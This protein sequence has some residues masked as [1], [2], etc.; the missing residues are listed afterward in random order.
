MHEADEIREIL[1]SADEKIT[2][3]INSLLGVRRYLK[4]ANEIKGIIKQGKILDWGSGWGQMSYLLKNRGFDVVSYEVEA[5]ESPLV[6]KTNQPMIIGND[7]VKLPFPDVYF[8]AVLSSGVLEHVQDDK[9]SIG[10]IARILKTKGYF[11]IFMLPNRYSYIEYLSDRLGR[12]AHPIKYSVGEIHRL[13]KE[14]GF[15]PLEFG[16][17]NFLP[18]NLKGFP[19][20]IQRTYHKFDPVIEALDNCFINLPL[21]NRLSTNIKVI[22]RK[23]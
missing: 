1:S 3:N 16:Y 21:L 6:K 13:L 22:A 9:A 20:M 19:K 8:D 2:P 14:K 7:P 12:G 5:S 4:M 11:V 18:Y 17:Q 23:K 15:E 10:E